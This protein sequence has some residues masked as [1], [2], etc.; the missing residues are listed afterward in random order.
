MHDAPTARVPHGRDHGAG[1]AGEGKQIHLERRLPQLVID[2]L[3]RVTGIEQ[4][5]VVHQPIDTAVPFDGFRHDPGRGVR[6]CEVGGDEVRR[7]GQH[8]VA[9]IAAGDRHDFRPFVREFVGGGEADAAGAA[10]DDDDAAC[11][12]EM[13]GEAFLD[14]RVDV[15]SG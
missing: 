6:C 2:R 1:E 9:G 3:E 4:G 10:G 14:C 15:A 8:A 13:H 12:I 11:E 7:C 5:G